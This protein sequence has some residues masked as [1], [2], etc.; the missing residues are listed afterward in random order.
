MFSPDK[1]LP[2]KERILLVAE[3]LFAEKG[4]EGASLRDITEKAGVNL[5]SVN[6]HFGSKDSLISAVFARYFTPMNKDRLALLDVVERKAGDGPPPLEAVMDA[7]IRPVVVHGIDPRH[8]EFMRLA[9]RCLSEPASHIAKYVLPHF[10]DLIVRF[11]DVVSRCLPS[12]SP[13]EI[14][15]RMNFILG[16]LHHTLHVWSRLDILTHKP[17]NRTKSE[18]LIRQLVSFA[19]AGLKIPGKGWN[20]SVSVAHP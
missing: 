15:W 20:E 19:T 5:A 9:G 12:L 3:R 13:D 6:Y 11:D 17:E 10:E 1:H 14:F 2:T 16:A 18:E 4:V 8:G 7:Y